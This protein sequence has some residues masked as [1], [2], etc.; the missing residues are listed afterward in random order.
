MNGVE[1]KLK[2]EFPCLSSVCFNLKT[3]KIVEILKKFAY[4][5][6]IKSARFEVAEY[7]AKAIIE[8]IFGI[9]N[10]EGGSQLLPADWR[11][12]YVAKNIA[13]SE[14]E[15]KEWRARTVCDFV[16]CM[17]D[18]YCLEFYSRLTGIEA[19]SIHKPFE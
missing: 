3:F 7:H 4:K 10:T 18:R 15:K 17:T 8:T 11:Q 16:A 2:P 14:A 1:F 5:S 12:V 13:K 19:P 9:L 6:L